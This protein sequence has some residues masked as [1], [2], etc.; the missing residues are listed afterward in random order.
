MTTA[1]TTGLE[2]GKRQSKTTM[3]LG[4]WLCYLAKKH[5]WQVYKP[6]WSWSSLSPSALLERC[7]VGTS[8][9]L[10]SWV[11]SP[12]LGKLV[13]IEETAAQTEL[14]PISWWAET[15]FCLL[16]PQKSKPGICLSSELN[17]HRHWET[18]SWYLNISC[19]SAPLPCLEADYLNISQNL[20]HAH[21]SQSGVGSRPL[22]EI[23]SPQ[24]HKQMCSSGFAKKVLESRGCGDACGWPKQLLVIVG[25]SV[26]FLWGKGLNSLPLSWLG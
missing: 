23:Y 24:D 6:R 14:L 5:V 4:K 9:K 21:L 25:E 2:P 16:P 13:Q 12:G 11:A 20:L 10:I 22:V 3:P 26:W 1:S 17:L 15:K 7:Q 18:Y 8:A 19:M